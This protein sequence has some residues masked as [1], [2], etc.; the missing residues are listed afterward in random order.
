M[1]LSK[2]ASLKETEPLQGLQT[3]KALKP[4]CQRKTVSNAEILFLSARIVSRAVEDMR[5]GVC[6]QAFYSMRL[7]QAM[8]LINEYDTLTLSKDDAKAICKSLN[9]DNPLK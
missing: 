8:R 3:L 7:K 4:L 6:S 1:T 5:G 2:I 9:I